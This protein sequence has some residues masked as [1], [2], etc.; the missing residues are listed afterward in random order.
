MDSGT[1]AFMKNSCIWQEFV[2][3]SLSLMEAISVISTIAW[4]FTYRPTIQFSFL[5]SIPDYFDEGQT[6][7]LASVM[8]QLGDPEADH[9]MLS[10]IIEL[11]SDARNHIVSHPLCRAFS[12]R[13]FRHADEIYALLLR[14]SSAHSSTDAFTLRLRFKPLNQPASLPS[15]MLIRRIAATLIDHAMLHALDPLAAVPASYYRQVEDRIRN[16]LASTLLTAATN[17][18]FVDDTFE[19]LNFMDQPENNESEFSIL[20]ELGATIDRSTAMVEEQEKRHQNSLQLLQ[21][22]LATSQLENSKSSHTPNSQHQ[23]SQ[24]VSVATSPRSS[25]EE[26]SSLATSLDLFLQRG[27]FSQLRIEKLTEEVEQMQAQVVAAQKEC[28]EHRA[29]AE[30]AKFRADSMQRAAASAWG[31]ATNPS[32]PAHRSVPS[33]LDSWRSSSSVGSNSSAS[34]NGK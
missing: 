25:E 15:T 20:L 21:N 5:L 2:I 1:C 29:A 23:S 4:E 12:Q 32:S 22:V 31:F 13:N 24:R 26:A 27:A 10:R 14:Y 30:A 8:S 6:K 33:G 11:I 7:D 17:P 9:F 3:R 28:D 18:S 19:T 34:A 16:K